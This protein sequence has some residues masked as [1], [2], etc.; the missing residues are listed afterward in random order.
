MIDKSQIISE[1][2]IQQRS[3]KLSKNTLDFTN[4]S[5]LLDKCEQVINSY[6][7]AKPIMRVIH[8]FACSGGTL[9]TKCLSSMANTFILSEVHPHFY[10]HLQTDM[11]TFLPSDIATLAM[12]AG[13]P[14]PNKLARK[15]FHQSVKSAHE[16]VDQ[17]GGILVL[18]DHSHSDFCVGAEYRQKT[19]I[20]EL[21]KDDFNVISVATVRNPIDAYSSLLA[22]DWVHF[23]PQTF[24]AYC[25]RL[26][27]FL[28]Q[29][30]KENIIYYEDFVDCPPQ[31]MEKMCSIL[32]IEYDESFLDLY[33]QFK[34]SGDSGR[35]TSD[36]SKRGRREVSAELKNEIEDSEYF[37]LICND[38]EFQGT[39]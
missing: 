26:S 5:S 17:R 20:T 14:D 15:I 18:R 38:Y 39:V 36:I 33:D 37:R 21:L 22:N 4:A 24:D 13:V 8:H 9:F 10:Q 29:F 7:S 31:I 11:A 25:E 30:K 16:H 3:V 35:K 2:S 34:V 12:Q 23:S 32:N 1:D 27:Q 28:V 6:Q 19:L